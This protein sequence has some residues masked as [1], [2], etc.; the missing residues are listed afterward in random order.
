M[1]K[2]GRQDK[3]SYLKRTPGA[4]SIAV[5]WGILTGVEDIAEEL[6]IPL[7]SITVSWRLEEEIRERPRS[8]LRSGATVYSTRVD[9]GVEREVEVLGSSLRVTLEPGFGDLELES[10]YMLAP[11]LVALDSSI[12]REHALETTRSGI[13]YL[14][15]YLGSGEVAVFEGEAYRVRLPFVPSSASLH[16]HPE[17]SCGLSAQDVQ[18]GLDLLV[19]GG[20]FEAAATPSCIAFMARMGLVSEEDYIA[21]RE[22]IVRRRTGELWRRKLRTVR[23]GVIAY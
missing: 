12:I 6:G 21:I 10:L 13:E 9:R 1:P 20:L 17:G 4:E 18:S 3:T 2:E 5:L 8:L 15:I 19:E 7:G 16:T 11:Q 22:A 23:F 14:M